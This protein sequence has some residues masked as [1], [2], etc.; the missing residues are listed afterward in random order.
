M[1]KAISSGLNGIN[2][3]FDDKK[4]ETGYSLPDSFNQFYFVGSNLID[5]I[6]YLIDLIFNMFFFYFQ[7]L[8][9]VR[10]SCR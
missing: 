10:E 1:Q 4:Q 7:K 8:F 6:N 2:L 9:R 3:Q 5:R